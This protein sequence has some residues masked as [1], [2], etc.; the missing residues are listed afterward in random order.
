MT[1]SRSVKEQDFQEFQW[2]QSAAVFYKNLKIKSLMGSGCPHPV[3]C[4]AQS[5]GGSNGL[6]VLTVLYC[7][8]FVYF[9]AR[10]NQ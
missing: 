7:R 3:H 9:C 4:T 2:Q 1:S 5:G 10:L 6:H 8:L